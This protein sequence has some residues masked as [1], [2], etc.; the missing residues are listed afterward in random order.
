MMENIKV[1]SLICEYSKW[2][3]KKAYD[4]FTHF[5]CSTLPNNID[6]EEVPYSCNCIETLKFK[7]ST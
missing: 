6:T 1:L 4:I 3:D 5:L 7:P 2:N